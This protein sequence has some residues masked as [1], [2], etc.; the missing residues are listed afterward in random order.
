MASEDT[1]P[2]S[3][4]VICVTAPAMIRDC[5]LQILRVTCA[6]IGN[7][8]TAL[9]LGVTQR[10]QGPVTT[11]HFLRVQMMRSLSSSMES[12]NVTNVAQNSIKFV[13]SFITHCK[14]GTNETKIQ[15]RY[16]ARRVISQETSMRL[17]DGMPPWPVGHGTSCSQVGDTCRTL[18][19]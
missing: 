1:L 4:K 2:R 14:C 18:L 11:V 9:K 19:L 7:R 10:S 3:S 17:E 6:W 15:K 16:C 5:Q 8:N 12:R 13:H